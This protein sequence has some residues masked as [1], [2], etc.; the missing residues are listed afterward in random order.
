MTD[1]TIRTGLIGAGIG[2]SFSRRLHE[3]EARA[4]GLHLTYQL[5]DIDTLGL[6]PEAVSTLIARA[7]TDGYQGLNITHPCKQL[8]VT[9]LDA[10][11]DE[12][13]AIGAVN[14]VVFE[15]DKSTGHNT[16][17]AGFA[18]AYATA[19]PDANPERV[20]LIGAGG[21]GAAVAHALLSVGTTSLAVIDTHLPRAQHL[22]A[23]LTTH[24]GP[25]RIITAHP[26]HDVADVLTQ[27]DGLVHAT[28]TGMAA[29]P[30]LPLPE[31][32]L[33]ADLWVADIVY[34]PLQTPLLTAAQERGCRTMHGGH[35]VVHQAVDAF[36]LFTG[37][38]A[39][40]DRMLRHLDQLILEE[41]SKTQG[42]L[43]AQ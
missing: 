26:P 15:G 21:A 1:H 19:L 31:E 38:D 12:A 17:S 7:H 40:T 37:M 6:P 8:A 13:R 22:V 43:P 24:H 9:A 11:S 42:R 28:P 32:L 33:T 34:R 30:G 14:T 25:H 35:M 29:H 4:A 27:A 23:R 16:D 3:T 18:K 20:V 39:D 5:F 41:S 10:L 36:R 2:P